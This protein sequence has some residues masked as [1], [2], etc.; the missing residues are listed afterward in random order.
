M[1]GTG[2]DDT[3]YSAGWTISGLVTI[4]S[5]VAIWMFGI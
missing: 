5:I 4:A 1:L 3:L 2:H